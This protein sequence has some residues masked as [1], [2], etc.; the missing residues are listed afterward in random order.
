M[1]R[2]IHLF[3]VQLHATGVSVSYADVTIVSSGTFSSPPQ[4]SSEP[5]AVTPSQHPL[6]NTTVLLVSLELSVL[7]FA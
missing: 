3:N 2:T 1:Y 4:R 7:D 6:G 5:W